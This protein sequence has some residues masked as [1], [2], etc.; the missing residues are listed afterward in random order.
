MAQDGLLE[1][2]ELRPRLEAQLVEQDASR[3]LVCLQRVRLAAH[4]VEREH[5]LATQTLSHRVLGHESLELADDLVVAAEAEIS[6]E[7]ALERGEPQ[8]FEPGDLRLCER[9]VVNVDKRWPAP[10]GEGLDQQLG[11]VD[12]GTA[13]EGR[14]SL[15]GKPFEPLGVQPIW[16]DL[17]AVSGPVPDQPVLDHLAQLRHVDLERVGGGRR[18]VLAPE[19][20]DQ[21]FGRDDFVPVQEE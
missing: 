10:E 19:V 18:W 15:P 17:K 11:R 4:T 20:V 1:L 5:Q 14:C 7:P 13:P 12:V 3:I 8:L 2:A 6:F 9:L 21:P 16:L